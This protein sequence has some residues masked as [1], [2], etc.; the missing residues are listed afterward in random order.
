MT[1][2]ANRKVGIIPSD[3]D[4]LTGI[5]GF[6]VNDAKVHDRFTLAEPADRFHFLDFIGVNQH[7]AA[8]F[9]Q[10][11]PEII[12]QSEAHDR[13]VKLIYD[14]NELQDAVLGQE[15]AF[16]N[17]NA[18]WLRLMLLHNAVDVGRIG[19]RYRFASQAD[20]RGYIS[21]GIAVIDSGCKKEHRFVLFFVV[22]GDFQD[23]D[24]LTT[25]HGAV[26]KK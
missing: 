14:P 20:S 15:L 11:V 9:K 10:L 16:V 3:Q 25:V 6:T 26:L 22:M 17:Q 21:N 23:F 7:P 2:A 1:F 8:A 18:V 5:Y 12:L 13:H 4:L 24:G 19:Y